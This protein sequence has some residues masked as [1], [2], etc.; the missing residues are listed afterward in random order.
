M[1]LRI[2]KGI[3]VND[4]TLAVDTIK[5]VGPGGNYLMEDHTIKYMRDEF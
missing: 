4:E 3:N 2:L 5:S 1:V